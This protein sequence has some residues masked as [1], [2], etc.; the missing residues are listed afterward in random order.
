M[1]LYAQRSAKMNMERNGEE[2]KMC[3]WKE[4]YKTVPAETIPLPDVEHSTVQKKK[5]VFLFNYKNID[6][7]INR[8]YLY[9]LQFHIYTIHTVRRTS[10]IY[11]I[12]FFFS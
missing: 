7:L 6:F 1:H 10:I 3:V 4:L 2:K 5:Y 11:K 9:G 12:T 8:K